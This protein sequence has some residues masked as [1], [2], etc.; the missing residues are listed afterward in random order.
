MNIRNSWMSPFHNGR[1]CSN[2]KQLDRSS[3]QS[4]FYWGNVKSSTIIMFDGWSD[5]TFDILLTFCLLLSPAD[6]AD[7]I[8]RSFILVQRPHNSRNIHSSSFIIGHWS[9]FNK[10]ARTSFTFFFPPHND[11]GNLQSEILQINWRL[12]HFPRTNNV[13]LF[14]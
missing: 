3:D 5:E 12:I 7:G 4:V 14:V 9:A 10:T 11:S 2:K 6:H 13:L 1:K 8:S